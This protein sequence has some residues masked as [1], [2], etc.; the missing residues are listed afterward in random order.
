M[1]R[2]IL[3][4]KSGEVMEVQD[5]AKDGQNS[6]NTGGFSYVSTL[7]RVDAAFAYI[8][9]TSQTAKVTSINSPNEVVV[10]LFSQGSADAADEGQ[11]I[12]ADLHIAD[13]INLHAYRL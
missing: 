9:S 8:Q 10:Q 3:E 7:G 5:D 1:V 2:R 6:Y 13:A 11:E 4:A 12:D